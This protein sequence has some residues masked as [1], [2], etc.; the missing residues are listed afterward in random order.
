MD[1]TTKITVSLAE[2]S[3]ITQA[4]L[5]TPATHAVELAE[6]CLCYTGGP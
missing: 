5:G 6:V 2:L 1:S 4:T 3:R